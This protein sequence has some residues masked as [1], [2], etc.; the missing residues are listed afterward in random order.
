MGAHEDSLLVINRDASEDS[1]PEGLG[2]TVKEVE[3]E[4]N[5]VDFGAADVPTKRHL[6]DMDMDETIVVRPTSLTD[7][8]SGSGD[9]N[10]NNSVTNIESSTDLGDVSSLSCLPT[11]QRVS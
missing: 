6:L 11:S 10:A 3:K 4:T 2:P 1:E 9:E 8:D 5:K 7:W